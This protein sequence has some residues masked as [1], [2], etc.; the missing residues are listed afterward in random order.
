MNNEFN[1][2]IDIFVSVFKHLFPFMIIPI[3]IHSLNI[4]YRLCIHSD[5]SIS[6]SYS[7][8]DI[9]P[10]LGDSITDTIDNIINSDRNDKEALI[11]WFS[12][13]MVG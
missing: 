9:K 2:F 12:V 5:I 13:N 11:E 6:D 7:E 10:F 3:V 1:E 4:A 8:N